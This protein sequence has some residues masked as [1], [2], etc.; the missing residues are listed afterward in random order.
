MAGLAGRSG[1]GRVVPQWLLPIDDLLNLALQAR[2]EFRRVLEVEEVFA[3]RVFERP[4]PKGEQCAVYVGKA[5]LEVEDV[6]KVG[7]ERAVSK[8]RHCRST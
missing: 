6:S 8:V 5:A 3:D 2:G 1:E 7:F 4:L